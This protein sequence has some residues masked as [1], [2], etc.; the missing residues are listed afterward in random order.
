MEIFS[1]AE[2]PRDVWNHQISLTLFKTDYVEFRVT[3]F[4][5]PQTTALSKAFLFYVTLFY[6]VVSFMVVRHCRLG[7]DYWA[8]ISY[9]LGF[10]ALSRFGGVLEYTRLEL[11][12]RSGLKTGN[13]FLLMTDEVTYILCLCSAFWPF[14][15]DNK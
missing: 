12:M 1:L 5:C 4:H 6:S 13:R 14:L 15:L 10:M 7:L 11:M 8:A 9:L 3:I 2:A